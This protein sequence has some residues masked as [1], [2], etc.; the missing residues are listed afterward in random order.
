M[1]KPTHYWMVEHDLP[2]MSIDPVML[3]DFNP[4]RGTKM[5][6]T[7]ATDTGG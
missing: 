4:C 3:S 7:V 2:I 6:H 1:Q 5:A